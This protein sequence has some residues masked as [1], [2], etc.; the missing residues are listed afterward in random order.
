MREALFGVICAPFL[1]FG[2]VYLENNSEAGKSRIQQI[3]KCQE[4]G[5]TYT[6]T[7]RNM[8]MCLKVEKP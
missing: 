3:H 4:K 7:D 8:V 2:L 1:L 6:V 5:M